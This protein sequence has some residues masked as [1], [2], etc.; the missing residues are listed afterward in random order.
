MMT[1]FEPP[2]GLP[3]IDAIPPMWNSGCAARRGGLNGRA[4]LR[5][6]R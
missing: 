5:A 4:G 2:I 3:M 6:R 1:I